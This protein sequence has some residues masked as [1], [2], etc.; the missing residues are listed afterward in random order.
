MKKKLLRNLIKKIALHRKNMEFNKK[1]IVKSSTN[2]LSRIRE[3]IRDAAKQC[4]FDTKTIGKITLA[5]DEACTNVIKHA[6]KYSPEGDISI[7]V[8]F[9]DSK[10]SITIK[11][12]G[13]H[14]DPTLVPEPNIKEYYKQKRIGGLGVFLM[15]K[16]MDEVTY[17]INKSSNQ[18]VLVKYLN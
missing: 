17:T 14:F 18:V 10:L 15:K 2:N 3:F 12:I 11:D 7:K 6:Y 13:L 1:L 5:V 9:A 4:G 16:L 8:K